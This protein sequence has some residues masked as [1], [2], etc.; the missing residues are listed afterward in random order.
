MFVPAI[1]VFTL[2][3]LSLPAHSG[4]TE[5]FGEYQVHYNALATDDIPPAVATGFGIVRSKNRAL[6]NI[7]VTRKHTSGELPRTQPVEAEVAVEAS[8]LTGQ[9]KDIRLRKVVEEGDYKATYYIA[10]I[11]ITDGETLIFNVDVRPEGSSDTF[12]VKFKQQFFTN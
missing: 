8:N 3:V 11:N 1:L 10:E 6:L 5:A 9:V 7:S 4:G 12:N 2:S